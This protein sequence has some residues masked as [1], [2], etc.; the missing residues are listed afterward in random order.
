LTGISANRL[1]ESTSPYLL[2][3]KDNPVHWQP[4]DD[5]IQRIAQEFDRP[6]LLSI[7]YAACHWCHVMAHESFED[8]EV[9]G[10]M[11]RLFVNIKVDR[12]ERPDIDQIYMAALSA[13]GEQGGWPLTMAL[14]PDGKPFWGGTYFPKY[15]R[16]GRPGFIDVLTQVEAAY[17]T[18]REDID[19]NANLLTEHLRERLAGAADPATTTI[20]TISG[21]ADQVAELYDPIAAGL[22]GAPKFP[23]APFL[24][25]LWR[26]WL[27]DGNEAARDRFLETITALST[28]GIYDHLGG[29][30]ARYAVDEAWLVPHFEKMLYDNAHFIRHCLWAHQETGN[31][32]FR[33]RIEE[34]VDWLTRDMQMPAGGFAASLDADSEGEEGK[35]YVWSMDEIAQTLGTEA[36]HSFANTYDV[37]PAGNWEGNN[38]LNLSAWRRNP[39]RIIAKIENQR[40]NRQKLLEARSRR[41]PPSKDTKILADWNGYAIRAIAEAAR[42]FGNESWLELAANQFLTLTGIMY[43][44]GKLSHVF[45]GKKTSS[46]GF[47]TDYAAMAN[48]ALSLYEATAETNYVTIAEQLAA[49]LRENHFD[50]ESSRGYWMGVP[51][52]ADTI[53]SAWND[54]DEA[55]PSATAQI[56]EALIRLALINEDIELKQHIDHVA[57]HAAGRITSSRSGQGGFMNAMDAVLSGRK[58]V[59]VGKDAKTDPLWCYAA[60]KTDPRRT[61][62]FLDISAGHETFREEGAYLCEDMRCSLPAKSVAELERLMMN[63]L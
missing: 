35:Y 3:H 21:F 13:M 46:Y 36:A 11:N 61:D 16:Y 39:K 30:I 60:A 56:I 62:C 1:G 52:N 59:V 29:G 34:T 44:N 17:R 58:L 51:E 12:E 33:L 20:G 5:E 43:R 27:R 9:A 2:Q 57:A 41:I 6:I 50:S 28:A 47:A 37:N 7:G 48:A 22:R 25:L 24:E 23:N 4:W 32:L 19:A 54:Q 49:S 63:G 14:T 38:I 18:R 8:A 45:D 42:R 10:V 40:D 53:M 31:V 26:A 15:P 55:N